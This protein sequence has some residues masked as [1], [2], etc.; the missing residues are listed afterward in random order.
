[1]IEIVIM[2]HKLHQVFKIVIVV[3]AQQNNKIRIILLLREVDLA[4]NINL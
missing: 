3:I 4:I 1:M 2:L